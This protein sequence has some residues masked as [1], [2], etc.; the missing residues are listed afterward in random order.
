MSKHTF[1][2]IFQRGSVD[3]TA[4]I[5]KGVAVIT[6]GDLLDGRR[7]ATNGLPMAVDYTTLEQIMSCAKT[8][9]T[10]LKVKADHRS[11]IF[12]VTGYLRNFHI[13]G[14]T[15][16]ADLYVLEKDENR[17]KLLEMAD[18]IPDTFGLSV[19]FSGPD[20]VLNGKSMSRCTE[21]YSAD[22]VSEPAANPT[23]LF[24]RGA[25][26]DDANKDK[27]M[28]PEEITKQCKAV[29]TECMAEYSS[30]LS[31]LEKA[32]AALKPD[33]DKD[34][35]GKISNSVKDLEKQLVEV[36]QKVL[37]SEQVGAAIAKEFAAVIGTVKTSAA[38]AGGEGGG[39]KLEDVGLSLVQ[40]H[41]GLTKSKAK[42]FEAAGRENSKAVEALVKSG[43]VIAYEKAA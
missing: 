21:I 28:T 23:G 40:K 38:P 16:R 6:A 19:S 11:G 32:F 8:Y 33:T 9:G 18:T 25:A 35:M 17:D 22:L 24:Q 36:K 12:A 27:T 2:S 31:V 41:F 7:D 13:E 4:G 1:A 5:I 26:I 42:A 30:K 37:S 10:G 29:F 14:Q 3:K 43:K 34:E 39:D 20:E 15:L